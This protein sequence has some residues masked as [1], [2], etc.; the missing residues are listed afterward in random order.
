MELS[1]FSCVRKI[2]QALYFLPEGREIVLGQLAEARFGEGIRNGSD[3]DRTGID[4]NNLSTFGF[5][6]PQGVLATAGH[7]VEQV[8]SIVLE[9][10]LDQHF[11]RQS[12]AE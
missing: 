1:S 3:L 5:E 10:S 9:G 4:R 11:V 12:E 2:G 8:A 7:G 6:H